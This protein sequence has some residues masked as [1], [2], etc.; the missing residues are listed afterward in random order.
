MTSAKMKTKKSQM[1]I[2]GL[3]II[4]ILFSLG[5]LFA[6][7]FMST[8]ERS[9]VHESFATTELAANMLNA[10][11]KT[12]VYDCKG[13]D[14]T[15]LFRDCAAY[16]SIDCDDDGNVYSQFNMSDSCY[17]LERDIIYIFNQTLDSWKKNYLF[18]AYIIE[19]EP[20]SWTP[21]SSGGC[22]ETDVGEM[23]EF[24]I[25]TDAGDLT[26]MLHICI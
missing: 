15:D 9:S 1:E 20:L 17:K 5:L 13:A 3:L 18:K 16:P 6:V 21:L 22:T 26:V 11:L 25:P 14:M 12:T 24:T 8:R 10:M 2:M 7:R 23:K 4:I 19:S